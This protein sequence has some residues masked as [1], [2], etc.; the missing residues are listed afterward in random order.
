MATLSDRFCER[1][2]QALELSGISQAE[3]ARRSGMTRMQVNAFLKGRNTGASLETVS[4]YAEALG[5]EPWHL[6]DDTDLA[7]VFENSHAA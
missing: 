6:L 2:A 7:T 5:I 4:R 3:L 1:L